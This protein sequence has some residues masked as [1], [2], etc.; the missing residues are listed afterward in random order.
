MRA[1]IATARHFA[2]HLLTQ[3]P[4]LRDTIVEGAAGVLALADDE[5]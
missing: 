1:K 2:D 4:G 3:A 5:F